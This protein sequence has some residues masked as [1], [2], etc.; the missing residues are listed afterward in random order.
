MGVSP[1]PPRRNSHQATGATRGG[2]RAEEAD[3]EMPM[4]GG[5]Q[6]LGRR[7]AQLALPAPWAFRGGCKLSDRVRGW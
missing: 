5:G 2:P 1:T 7:G 3:S 4:P 6:G